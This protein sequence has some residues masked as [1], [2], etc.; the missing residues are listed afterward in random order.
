MSHFSN[1]DKDIFVIKLQRMIDR[2]AL[3]SRYSRTANLNLRDL[4]RKEFENNENRGAD[5]Y[6]RVFL[7][8]G[9]ESVAELE[10]LQQRYW[11]KAG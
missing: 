6:K 10:T 1:E 2:G 7:E 8:Y 5:F 9:D 11:R 3:I 4:Y